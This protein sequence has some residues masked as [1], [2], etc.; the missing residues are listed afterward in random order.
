M[1]EKSNY[2]PLIEAPYSAENAVRESQQIVSFA[3]S[4]EK[5]L[6]EWSK[7]EKHVL[8]TVRERNP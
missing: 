2:L 8:Q 3:R 7:G 4:A 1:K 5:K 6:S